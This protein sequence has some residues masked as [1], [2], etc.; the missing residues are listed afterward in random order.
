MKRLFMGL[1]G[2]AA[3]GMVPVAEAQAQTQ[4]PQVLRLSSSFAPQGYIA[5]AM[6]FF[7]S[8]VHKRSQGRLKIEIYF[9]S[10]LGFKNTVTLSSMK[11]GLVDLSEWMGGNVDGELPMAGVLNLPFLHPD[12]DKGIKW[13]IERLTPEL[14]KETNKRW[15]VTILAAVGLPAP[16]E[17]FSNAPFKTLKD[18]QDVKI[19]S[20]GG[21]LGDS[22][23]YIG[24]KPYTITT[25]ELYTALQR[26]MV[27]ASITSVISATETRFWEVLKYV[28]HITMSTNQNTLGIRNEVLKKLPPELQAAVIDSGKALTQ[29]GLD[30][31]KPYAGKLLKVL[32]DNGM[33]EVWPEPGEVEKMREKCKPLYDKFVAELSPESLPLLKDLGVY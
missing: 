29:W 25:S 28:N 12:Y 4:A 24:A 20:W 3:L 27:D 26:G 8:E 15:D 22:L 7:A 1:L 17:F 13:Q 9:N 14:N 10:S 30:N 5:D 33:K 6:N 31:Y 2:A 32:T 19:R 11:K 18:L 23:Y 21:M 16:T